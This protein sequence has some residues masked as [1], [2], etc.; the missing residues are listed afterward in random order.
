MQLT[1]N[2]M[3]THLANKVCKLEQEKLKLKRENTSLKQ[4]RTSTGFL[5]IFEIMEGKK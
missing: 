5:T 3:I 2:K 1:K 4:T